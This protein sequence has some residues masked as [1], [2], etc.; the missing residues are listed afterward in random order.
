MNKKIIKLLLCVAGSSILIACAPP[1]KNSVDSK[2]NQEIS[3]DIEI[4]SREDFV[5]KDE[6]KYHMMRNT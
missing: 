4:S 5:S 1:N 6:K 2:I 3:N